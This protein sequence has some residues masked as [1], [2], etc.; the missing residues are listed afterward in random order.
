MAAVR[1][2]PLSAKNAILLVLVV[3][4][5]AL[6]SII[7]TSSPPPL[8]SFFPC[9]QPQPSVAFAYPHLLHLG[10]QGLKIFTPSLP[11]PT[12]NTLMNKKRER[13]TKRNPSTKTWPSRRPL[14]HPKSCDTLCTCLDPKRCYADWLLASFLFHGGI[15]LLHIP[16]PPHTPPFHL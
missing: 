6:A 16:T 2:T 3:Y 1:Y 13:E 14:F 10:H 15:R 7:V 12:Q 4:L 11:A 5:D 8:P 9:G